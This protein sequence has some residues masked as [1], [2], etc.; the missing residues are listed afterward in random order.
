M[1]QLADEGMKPHRVTGALD[2]DGDGRRQCR[3]ESLH[4]IPVMRKLLLPQL[5]RDGVENSHL[6]LSR[7]QV[8]PHQCHGRGLLSLGSPTVAS[9]AMTARVL[10]ASTDGVASLRGPGRDL[11][12]AAMGSTTRGEQSDRR[13]KGLARHRADYARCL[14]GT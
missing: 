13:P 10:M 4:G 14:G 5:T 2:G 11:D 6:L 3:I 1:P 12:A 8:A 7:V 9:L